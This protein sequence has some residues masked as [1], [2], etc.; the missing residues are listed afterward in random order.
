MIL[1]DDKVEKE[2]VDIYELK[3][4]PE[5]HAMM[6]EKG[7]T[8]K[9]GTKVVP[10]RRVQD[11]VKKVPINLEQMPRVIA[12]EPKEVVDSMTRVYGFIGGSLLVVGVLF[13]RKKPKRKVKSDLPTHV[14]AMASV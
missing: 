6:V 1:Y 9:S 5:M 12:D 14:K 10:E 4:Q 3:T 11:E 13:Y 2:R 8:R 7:F